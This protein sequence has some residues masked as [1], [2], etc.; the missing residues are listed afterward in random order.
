V[1]VETSAIESIQQ[2]PTGDA[3]NGSQVFLFLQGPLSP[4]FSELATAL[5]QRG[6][7]ILRINVCIGD[8]LLW[9]RP[10]A[11]NFRGRPETWPAYILDFMKREGVTD[12]VLLGEQRFY[13]KIAVAVAQRLGVTVTVTDFGYL[14]PDWITLELDG[15][16]GTSRFPRDMAAIRRIAHG[17]EP[18]E[19][20]ARYQDSF[21]RQVF[22]DMLFHLSNTFLNLFGFPHYRSYQLHHPVPAYIGTGIRL[23]LRA[24]RSKRADA[25]IRQLHDRGTPYFVLPMQM[26]NDF[27]LRAYS[28]FPDMVTPIR[29]AIRSLAAHG[30]GDAHLVVKIHPL[31]P[32]L[33]RWPSIVAREAKAAGM[34]DRLHFIDGGSLDIL[35]ERALGV[36]TVNSTVG[37][38]GLRAGKPVITLGQAT[39]D[40]PGLTYQDGLDRFWTE[41]NAPDAADVTAFM[42]ALAATIQIRGVYYNRPGLDAAVQNAAKR[43]DRKDGVSI[44]TRLARGGTSLAEPLET[45]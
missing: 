28:P 8:L 5:E 1:Y 34:T 18:P 32:G 37:I 12:L 15:M 31:D 36:V 14:R 35:L 23:L 26:E 30:A 41:A 29:Q 33:R 19:S 3:G 16:S 22:W 20:K 25:L 4:F 39:Y 38:W 17:A 10:G 27:Q 44:A 9:R 2:R 24:Q 40:I 45:L 42:T 11:A 21:P 43:L 13:Q 6:H 7:R